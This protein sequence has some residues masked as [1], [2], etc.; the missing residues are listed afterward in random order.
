[1]N[2]RKTVVI[3]LALLLAAVVIVPMLS[4]TGDSESGDKSD[5]IMSDSLVNQTST[6]HGETIP[7]IQW[8]NHQIDGSKVNKPL[9]REEFLSVN[10]EYIDFLEKTVGKESAD[11]Y[12]ND[13][14]SQRLADISNI[15]NE[16]R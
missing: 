10:R 7:A 8:V 1:M 9:T 11:Q 4:A 12:V 13:T 5:D 6:I 15:T 16:Q 14:L 3:L 2:N